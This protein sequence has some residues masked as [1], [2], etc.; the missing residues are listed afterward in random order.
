[1][2]RSE[3]STPMLKVWRIVTRSVALRM[4][5]WSKAILRRSD[6]GGPAEAPSSIDTSTGEAVDFPLRSSG[7]EEVKI[8]NPVAKPVSPGPPEHWLER[9]RQGAPQLLRSALHRNKRARPALSL[10]PSAPLTG[11]PA[12]KSQQASRSAKLTSSIDSSTGEAVESVSPG[13]SGVEEVKIRSL[14]TN[15]VSPGP[16]EHWLERVRRGAPQLSRWV[17]RRNK[18]MPLTLG[19]AASVAEKS[20]ADPD[21]PGTPPHRTPTGVPESRSHSQSQQ[22]F[23]LQAFLSPARL[24]NSSK[25]ALAKFPLERVED[26][27]KNS[28]AS[29]ADSRVESVPDRSA[30]PDERSSGASHE[31]LWVSTPPPPAYR[32]ATSPPQRTQF[33][34]TSFFCAEGTGKAALRSGPTRIPQEPSEDHWPQLPETAAADPLNEPEATIRERERLRRLDDEQRGI[35]GTRRIS[36]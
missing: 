12:P 26:S 25:A 6:A 13:S 36:A 28:S 9:V 32:E 27:Q 8:G 30:G 21:F 7:A 14:G 5:A 3:V 15:P 10:A 22:K 18:R 2:L 34:A 17:L 16:P 19:P 23:R 11:V 24:K 1:M 20:T 33:R 31:P 4:A 35:Y 29:P